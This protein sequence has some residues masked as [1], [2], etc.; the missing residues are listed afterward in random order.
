[1]TFK[2]EIFR[3]RVKRD[4]NTIS[5]VKF[6]DMQAVALILLIYSLLIHPSLALTSYEISL[7]PT[8]QGTWED[9]S[10]GALPD[11]DRMVVGAIDPIDNE[12]QYICRAKNGDAMVPGKLVPSHGKCYIARGG[13]EHGYRSYQILMNRDGYEFSWK[14]SSQGNFPHQTLIGGYASGWPMPVC[15]AWHKGRQGRWRWVSGKLDPE[16]GFQCCYIPYSGKE[17]CKKEYEVLKNNQ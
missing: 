15:R 7:I 13:S 9:S 6:R 8:I 17:H 5:S 16:P 4:Q 2:R 12:K 1:M 14:P 3:E 11:T 10:D